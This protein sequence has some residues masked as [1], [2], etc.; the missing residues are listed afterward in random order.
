VEQIHSPSLKFIGRIK[1]AIATTD[2]MPMQGVEAEAHIDAA[3]AEA[4]GGI[5]KCSHI[6]LLVWLHRSDRDRLKVV[7]KRIKTAVEEKGVFSLRSPIRPN[8]IGMTAVRLLEKTG[9]VLH[10]SHVD[11]IDGT[12]IIDIKPYSVGWDAIFSA[13]NNSSFHTYDKMPAEEVY[14]D[15]LRQAANF[16]G[17]VCVGTAIGMRAANLAMR[18]FKCDLQDQALTAK[19][20]TRGCVADAVQ[21]L[22]QAGGKRFSRPEPSDGVLAFS[23]DNKTLRLEPA[24]EKLGSVDEVLAAHDERIFSRIESIVGEAEGR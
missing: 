5:E 8:P 18:H 2:E 1:T 23:R 22:M 20:G 4:L 14:A 21:A 24:A 15:M 13:K 17:H 12:P 3:Y 9:N 7:P 11:F 6:W 16:H 10:L 19:I